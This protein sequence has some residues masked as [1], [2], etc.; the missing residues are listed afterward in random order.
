MGEEL[1]SKVFGVPNPPA[2]IEGVLAAATAAKVKRN[3]TGTKLVIR[4]VE[5]EE[6][7]QND[8]KSAPKT[9]DCMVDRIVAKV[10]DCLA[11]S[12]CQQGAQS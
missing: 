5:A 12:R 2:T 10:E 3:L 7:S 9:E 8:E 1:R 11:I 4:A 6:G